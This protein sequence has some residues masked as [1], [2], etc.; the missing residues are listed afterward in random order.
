[1]GL[2]RGGLSVIVS[3]IFFVLL[4]S[5]NIL[6]TLNSSLEYDTLKFNLRDVLKE[7]AGEQINYSQ[8]VDKDISQLQNYCKNSSFYST[9]ENDYNLVIN[10]S[11]ASINAGKETIVDEFIND[12]VEQLYYAEYSCNFVSCL[13]EKENV[14][15]LVSN[16]FHEDVQSKLYFLIIILIIS[17]AGIFL[18]AQKKHNAF[19]IGGILI[20]ISA[21]PFIKLDSLFSFVGNSFLAIINVFFSESYSIFIKMLILGL[22]VLAIG[23]ILKFFNIGFKISGLIEKF[24]TKFSKE[25]VKE[26]EKSKIQK[27]DKDVKKKK[28]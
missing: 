4:L 26:V 21:L 1:M 14:F 2:I 17:F 23:I 12:V 18:L 19:I 25:E 8:I 7:K 24:K 3:V 20:I 11:C 5:T 15:F 10:I 9:K 6:M 16:Q 22:I 28:S 13:Q 27:P